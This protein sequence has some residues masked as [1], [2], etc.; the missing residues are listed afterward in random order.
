MTGEYA[1]L[2]P[3]AAGNPPVNFSA[4]R[5]PFPFW[6][7]S[8]GEVVYLLG[9]ERNADKI[10]GASYVRSFLTSQPLRPALIE[11]CRHPLSKTSI[12]TNGFRI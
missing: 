6:I 5:A 10:I 3:N 2:Q 7:G 11:M 1:T 9:A 4:P 12:R 8:I